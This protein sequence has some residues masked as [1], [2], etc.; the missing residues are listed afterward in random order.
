MVVGLLSDHVCYLLD[1]MGLFNVLSTARVEILLTGLRHS[2]VKPI[3]SDLQFLQWATSVGVGLILVVCTSNPFVQFALRTSCVIFQAQHNYICDMCRRYIG[4]A[5]YPSAGVWVILP[6][7]I[8]K[9]RLS[10]LWVKLCLAWGLPS[11][12]LF[13]FMV[14]HYA[15]MLGNL[16]ASICWHLAFLLNVWDEVK[17]QFPLVY[18]DVISETNIFNLRTHTVTTFQLRWFLHEGIRTSHCSHTQRPERGSWQII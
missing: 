15:Q 12:W 11:L 13:Q 7:M 4:V 1:L 3:G 14:G 17:G 5:G 9:S 16:S 2:V 18:E 6:M 10:S 8:I